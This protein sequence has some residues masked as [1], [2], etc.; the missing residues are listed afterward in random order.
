MAAGLLRRVG[1]G[2]RDA[3]L[4][5]VGMAVA[6]QYVLI[7]LSPRRVPD[8]GRF[9]R[10]AGFGQLQSAAATWADRNFELIEDGAPWLERAGRWVLDRCQTGL[11]SRALKIPRDPPTL[12]CTREV[13]AVYGIDG[14]LDARLAD[15][16]A[17]LGR[18][19][20]GDRQGDTT[21]PLRDLG[22][23]PPPTWS[24]DWSPVAGFGL[25]AVLETMPPTR[26]FSLKSWLE[27]GIG[28]ISR[29]KP[30]AELVTT[31]AS[32]LTGELRTTT[33]T[34]HPV[35]VS[36]ADPG[37]LAGR[38]L[39]RHEHVIAI[40]IKIYYYLDSNVN[41]APGRLRKRLLPVPAW[42]SAGLGRPVTRHRRA[43]RSARSP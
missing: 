6:V 19:G 35:E 29:G 14:N 8:L 37:D 31:R 15:L 10:S 41:A 21:V 20:W 23:S 16:A 33:A 7:A 36:G 40:R 18:A 3:L 22:H 12:T 26:R 13:T 1:R 4:W 11:E 27:M 2:M 9:T 28:W 32:G 34:Y 39:A 17:V 5:P 43:S 25:P 24:V 38:A 30:T 42:S